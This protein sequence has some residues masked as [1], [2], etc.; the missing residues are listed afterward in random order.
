MHNSEK[1]EHFQWFYGT[2]LWHEFFLQ[3]G[4]IMTKRISEEEVKTLY[5]QFGTPAHVIGHCGAVS[6]VAV[7]LAEELK[8]HGYSLD[9]DLVRGSGLAHDVARTSDEHGAVGAE[10]LEALGYRDE[11]D[12]VRDHM[13]YT[14]GT[15]D[16][17]TECDMVCLADK[18]VCEDKYVGLMPRMEYLIA[19]IPGHDPAREARIRARW[20][21]LAQLIEDIEKIIGRS[22]DSLFTDEE[23]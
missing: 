23:N 2:I 5:E 14:I 4:L 9:L 10:A 18:L 6:H 15:A 7:K 1:S 20:D 12:I 8:K 11:A 3:K 13:Y 22:V 17:L 19:K 21:I 16:K